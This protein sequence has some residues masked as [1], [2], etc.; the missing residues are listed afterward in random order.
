MALH[1]LPGKKRKAAR[2]YPAAA[3]KQSLFW[4]LV[5]VHA[6]PGATI[7]CATTTTCHSANAIHREGSV[8][9]I[10]H[11]VNCSFDIRATM[12]HPE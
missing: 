8:E 1:Y 4:K 7:I 10:V 9:R 11:S 12:R 5:R 2:I 6:R 3:M